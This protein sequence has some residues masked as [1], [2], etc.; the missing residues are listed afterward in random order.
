MDWLDYGRLVA[1]LWVVLDHYCFTG[2]TPKINASITGYGALSWLASYGYAGLYFFFMTSGLVITLTAQK[3]SAHEFVVRRLVRIYPTFLVC[4][5]LTALLTLNGP[6]LLHVTPMRYLA[7]LTVDPL[8]FGYRPVDAVYWT[9][10][11]ELTF[12]LCFLLVIL[13]GQMRRLQAI[14]TLWVA[15]QLLSALVTTLKIPMLAESYYFLSAGA[16]LALIYQRRNRLLNYALL[17]VL[18]V[19]CLRAA[20][21]VALDYHVDQRPLLAVTAGLFGLFVAM[22]NRDVRLPFARR[23][24]S[25]TYPLYLLHFH[26]GATAIYLLGAPSNQWVL[27]PCLIAVMLLA[28]TLIDDV[29][30]FRLR[31]VWV[32][33]ARKLVPR[34][35]RPHAAQ[36]AAQKGDG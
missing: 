29:I 18:T 19:L 13:S 15:L 23:I 31:S 10:V 26:I 35:R 16:V 8:A 14:V 3:H 36:R 34:A 7:N 17:A 28:S 2:V 32:T 1:A 20:R 9:L 5:T 21:H 11:V 24:G 27:I 33:W 12:Y 22:R 6:A 25:M 30:E 4:M